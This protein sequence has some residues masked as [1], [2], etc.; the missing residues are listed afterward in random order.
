MPLTEE[1]KKEVE[2]AT[3]VA[4]KEYLAGIPEAKRFIPAGD[5]A[6]AAAKA[7]DVHPIAK[8]VTPTT[9]KSLGEQLDAIMKAA[10]PGST[11]DVRLKTISGLGE[12]VP[13]DGGFLIQQEFASEILKLTHETGQLA[14]RCRKITI[15]PNANGI[16]IPRVDESTRVDGSRWGGVLAYWKAEGAQKTTKKPAFGQLSLELHKLTGLCHATDE[17]LADSTALES[18]IR[19]AFA[20]EIGFKVDD[21]IIN[22][23]GAGKPLGIL[24]APCLVSV[25][26]ESGQAADTIVAE[27]VIKMWAQMYGPSRRNAVWLINQDIEP[28]LY[29]LSL[30]VGTGG[31]PVYM[32]PNGLSAQPYAT[33]YGRPVIPCEQCATLGDAGD[34]ILADLSQYIIIEKGGIDIASS[35]HLRFDY[36]ETA[37]R[38]VYRMDGQPAWAAALTPYKG[39]NTQ[40][41]FVVTAARA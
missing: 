39:S 9:F 7:E 15:G 17:M 37:F 4:V 3:A 12:Q 32:P 20:E 33:L 36:D 11:R 35:I 21:A 16:K 19:Q 29:T 31:I 28:Q 8:D 27:N 38:F 5:P 6:P 18:I 13:A 2:T 41:P 22:G 14:S 24:E 23:D 34:I 25:T 10:I 30:A 26:I 40:S 1:Q